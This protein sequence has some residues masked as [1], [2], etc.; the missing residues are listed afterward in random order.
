[1]TQTK[2]DAKLADAQEAYAGDSERVEVIS[3]TRRF[4]AS[5]VELGEALIEVKRR[6]HWRRWGHACFEDYTR[7]ELH[8]RPETVA[9]LVGSYQFLQ[10]RAPEVLARDG[11]QTP[12]P[13]YQAI[14]YLR[15]AESEE[16]AP[17][18]VL[19]AMRKKVL[20]EGAGLTSVVRQF[21]SQV[22]PVSEEARVKADAASV[23]N[24]AT[25]LK[26]LLGE[27]ETVPQTLVDE[28]GEVLDRLIA[29]LSAKQDAAA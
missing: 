9:K 13:S 16:H 4:K 29:E 24:A 10:S 11:V 14:D 28:L 22:F 3:R 19:E 27:T 12:L 20:D 25:R 15:R 21:K 23:K 8:L 6:S 7:V 5:W 26:H 18:D 2:V 1:M 17:K